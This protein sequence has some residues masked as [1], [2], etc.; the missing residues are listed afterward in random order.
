APTEHDLA[1]LYRALYG[2]RFLPGG[3]DPKWRFV[4]DPDDPEKSRADVPSDIFI[5][6][7][8]LFDWYCTQ[9]PW[10]Q[11]EKDWYRFFLV[12]E[13]RVKGKTL[14]GAY[15]AAA[16]RLVETTAKITRGGVVEEVEVPPC[17]AAASAHM[18]KKSY[19]HIVSS[20]PRKH[21]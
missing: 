11:E 1:E 13:E 19:Q 5:L 15:E 10:T 21:R 12:L 20:L 4:T 7:L 9:Q 6:L 14:E 8:R 3:G 18:V 17:P 16:A 2:W